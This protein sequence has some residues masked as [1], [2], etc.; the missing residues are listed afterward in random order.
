MKRNK[1][2]GPDEI[3]TEMLTSLEDFGME[4]LTELI[5]KLYNSGEIP[6]DLSKSIFTALP[7]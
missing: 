3:V 2:A 4:K 5:N 6:N 7:K 1:A